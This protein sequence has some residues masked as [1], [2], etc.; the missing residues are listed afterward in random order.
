MPTDG[1][2]QMLLTLTADQFDRVRTIVSDALDAGPETAGDVLALLDAFA[3]ARPARSREEMIF[4][5]ADVICD[6][7]HESIVSEALA[8]DGLIAAGV[9]QPEESG[10][11]SGG[12]DARR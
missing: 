9:I 7:R 1:L 5:L 4:I 11:P 6:G 8:E 2:S 12:L 10:A 3:A